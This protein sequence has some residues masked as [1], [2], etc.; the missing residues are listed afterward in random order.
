[1]AVAAQTAFSSDSLTGYFPSGV[2]LGLSVDALKQARPQAI[3]SSVNLLPQIDQGIS[4]STQFIERIGTSTFYTYIV[5]QGVVQGIIRSEPVVPSVTTQSVQIYASLQSGFQLVDSEQIARANGSLDYYP[6]SAEQW[7]GNDGINAY[8]V[9][10]SQET[11]LILFNP[12]ALSSKNFFIDASKIPSL[13]PGADTIRKLTKTKEQ[14]SEAIIDRPWQRNSASAM[15][16]QPSATPASLQ[17]PAEPSKTEVPSQGQMPLEA[18]QTA[19]TTLDVEPPTP[20]LTWVWIILTLLVI[21]ATIGWL[22]L[23]LR[24]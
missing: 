19:S 8:F 5:Q 22:I 23:R 17:Q 1:M 14:S 24:R 13:K 3:Q 15:T 2:Q 16:A 4:N 7:R 11:T 20:S 6:V 18:R 12:Q 10:T 9:S 21:S